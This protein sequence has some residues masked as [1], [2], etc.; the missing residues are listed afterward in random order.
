VSNFSFLANEWPDIAE[1]ADKAEASIQA[2]PRTSCF[3]ARRATELLVHWIYKADSTLR[4]PYQDN[5]GALLHEPTFKR[6]VGEVVLNK[7]RL[8]T[9]AGNRAVHDNRP[10]P[11]SASAAAVRELFHVCYWLAHTY[12]RGTKPAPGLAYNQEAAER[13]APAA[14]QTA[15]KLQEL[16]ASLAQRDESLTALLVDREALDAELVRLRAEVAQAKK[17]SVGQIDTHDY[18]EADTRAYIID[19]YLYEAG[20]PLTEKRDRE[21]EV[22]GMPNRQSTGYVD[23]VLWGSDAKP[24]ALVEAKRTTKSPLAGK[25][26]AKLYADCLEEE[27]GQRP[28]IFYS[29]GYQTWIWDDQMYPPREVQ[30]FYT[31]DELELLI[32]RRTSRKALA[33]VEINDAI[34]ERYYQTRAIRRIGEAFESDLERK[35][36]LV[37]ATGAGKTRTVIALS[38]L[39][40]RSNWTKRTLFLADRI[41]LVNQ[42]VGAFKTHLPSSS[43][44]NLVTDHH[45]DGRVYVSTYPT[46]MGLIDEMQDGRRR[47]GPGHFDLVVIDEAHRSVYQKYRAIFDYF[48]SLLVGLTATPKDEID[49]NTY[50]LFELERGVPTDAYQL[51]DAIKDGFLVPPIAVSVPIKFQRLGITYKDLSPEEQEKWDALEWGDGDPVPDKVESSAL[52][53]WLFNEDTV[54]KVLAHLMTEGQRVA[55]GDRIGKT[56]I[57]AKNHAHADFIVERFDANYPKFKGAFARTIHHGVT[58]AQS[59]IDDFSTPTKEPHIAVSVD[60]LDTGIDIPDVVNLVFF[61]QVRSKTK[62]WQMVGRGTR[63][64]PDL[65]GP[66]SDKKSFFILDYCGNLEFFSLDP[67]TA[68]GRLGETLSAKLFTTRLDLIA[69]LDHNPTMVAATEGANQLRKDTASLL[70][71]VVASMNLDNFVVRTKRQYVEKFAKAEAWAGLKQDDLHELASE[72][73]PLPSE[74]ESEMEEAKRFDL[75]MLNLQ[76]VFLRHDA[77]FSKLRDQVIAI[78][79]MLEE[80]ANIPAVRAQLAVLEEVQSDEWWQDVTVEMLEQVRK[81]LRDLVQ[82]IEKRSR[83]VLFTDFE[84]EIGEETSFELLGL[85]PAQGM[86]RFRAKAQA[87]LRQHED[88]VAIHRLRMNKPLTYHD[89]E[90]LEYMLSVNGIG[91]PETIARAKEENQGLGLFVRS[92]IGLDRGAAKEAFADFLD[93]RTY[94]A[95]QIEFVDLIINHLT[96]HGVMGAALLYESPFTDL[97]PHGP[98]DLF[99]SEEVDRLLVVLDDVRAAAEAA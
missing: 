90:V 95:N 66:G 21:Y 31:K 68:E 98:E 49:I 6:A 58:Y 99:S 78:A 82:F 3:Y 52:N 25:Q 73:A 77:R 57:F 15:A 46:M 53:A 70:Q 83:K 32:Q 33:A 87:F 72:V 27:F 67:A 88:H 34:V 2:D 92:L 42:A 4:L 54:D 12:A 62:F 97:A 30:G 69:E 19:E 10:I 55:G 5:L 76:L 93:G 1:A 85:A 13:L 16:E 79:G 38:D 96:E 17:E 35:A 45:G 50:Q 37:M 40:M 36:L 94:S 51:D 44:V 81:R 14:A 11:E 7:T 24:L 43:P 91:D 75:L 48:D 89:L 29:N 80:Q 26:Q 74:V 60:M 39:L 20:W 23:Y 28:V 71:G 86:D 9:R 61:K 47:F 59:L 22:S 84:D 65:F 18:T 63:L 64:R 41:A 56:I 8:I